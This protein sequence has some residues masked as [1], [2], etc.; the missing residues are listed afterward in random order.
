MSVNDKHL[1]TL[2]GEQVAGKRIQ[3]PEQLLDGAGGNAS[4]RVAALVGEKHGN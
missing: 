1:V 4:K 3:T 2:V